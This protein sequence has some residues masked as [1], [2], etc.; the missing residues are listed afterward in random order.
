[1]SYRWSD[2]GPED[3]DEYGT[4]RYWEQR[5][6]EDAATA[7]WQAEQEA[8]MRRLRHV[9][10]E[11]AR[12]R[13]L[14]AKAEAVLAVAAAMSGSNHPLIAVESWDNRSGLRGGLYI[15][16]DRD[17]QLCWSPRHGYEVVEIDEIPF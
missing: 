7:A 8:E 6:A 9:R 10:R 17:R 15:Y 11:S 1:V 3:P 5:D 13:K 16:L 2:Y 14:F 12:R 4:D